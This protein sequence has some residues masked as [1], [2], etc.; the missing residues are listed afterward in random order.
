MS[1]Q[2]RR[3]TFVIS[4][5]HLGGDHHDGG[6]GHE[7]GFRLCTQT[8]RLVRFIDDLPLRAT[9]GSELEL[10]INGDIVDF[11]AETDGSASG[12]TPFQADG[13]RAAATFQKIAARDGDREVFAALAQFLGR[14][15]RLVLLLGNH[16]VELALPAVRD[17]LRRA[18]GVGGRHDFHCVFDGEAYVVGNNA[19][20]EHGN[21]YDPWN[22]VD[23]D[24]L[25]ELR[26]WQTRRQDAHCTGIEGNAG[27]RL[28]CDVINPIKK[29]YGFVDLLKPET[30]AVLP[31]LLALEPG[32]RRILPAVLR[33]RA[34]AWRH[35]P[36]G[37]AQPRMRGDIA[38][39][40]APTV[41]SGGGLASMGGPV[42]AEPGPQATL[43]AALDAVMHGQAGRFLAQLEDGYDTRAGGGIAGDVAW[44][45]TSFDRASGLARLFVGR[46]HDS[47]ERRLPP[48]L[49]A[50]R[51]LQDDRSFRRDTETLTEYA[52]AAA[53]LARG[54]FDFVLFGHTHRARDVRL[55]GGAR[56]LNSGAWTDRLRIP[57]AVIE[58]AGTACDRCASCVRDGHGTR[59]SERVA[60]IRTDVR[61]ARYQQQRQR[62]RRRV[63]RL[64]SDGSI[65]PAWRT[66]RRSTAPLRL[67]DWISLMRPRPVVA[68]S[69][70]P[71]PPP[72]GQRR[73]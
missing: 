52:D 67:F 41:L 54:G 60:G 59:P 53:D 20:V 45:S 40:G 32:I 47:I 21:R 46:R 72:F 12:W 36:A 22:T 69:P 11:L 7:R 30:E 24:S 64:L 16:D 73:C 57:E 50:L 26:A 65:A 6:I 56:Y 19:L 34:A 44:T 61:A 49:H 43:Y 31:L 38:A 62:R 5:L 25:R 29:S 8:P 23:H 51:V 2:V 63:A 42:G 28:V 55:A 39:V 1:I 9:P 13:A 70:P 58:R 68:D 4:D 14:G 3:H 35:R 27:S 17:A 71:L 48:L 18:L 15:H 66:L 37:P 33:L 10:V